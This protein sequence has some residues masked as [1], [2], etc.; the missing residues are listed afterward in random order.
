M[1]FCLLF[2]FVLYPFNHINLRLTLLL[3]V[4]LTASLRR[5]QL[6]R[7]RCTGGSYSLSL[8]F[9]LCRCLFISFLLDLI[10]LRLLTLL[11]VAAVA[12]TRPVV[13]RKTYWLFLFSSQVKNFSC[14]AWNRRTTSPPFRMSSLFSLRR[15]RKSL[16]IL[17]EEEKP[18]QDV[19][20]F[21]REEEEK[22]LLILWGKEHVNNVSPLQ[23]VLL[24]FTGEEGK[25]K[26]Q[27]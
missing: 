11:L 22:C 24:V 12:A 17:W 8:F 20:V 10:N 26:S 2:L 6:F 4:A 25:K 7:E 18:L 23:D 5:T 13:R 1:V 16:L 3:V 27:C 19:L 9:S 15:K 21:T 14:S